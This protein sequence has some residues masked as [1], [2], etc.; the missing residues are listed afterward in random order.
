MK[1]EGLIEKLIYNIH[2]YKSK[3]MFDEYIVITISENNIQKLVLHYFEMYRIQLEYNEDLR[4]MGNKII[5][6]KM[7]KDD[8]IIIGQISKL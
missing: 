2:I 1:T 7:L 8:E 6:S 5:S 3:N 4:F